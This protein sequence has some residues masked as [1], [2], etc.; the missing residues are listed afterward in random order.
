MFIKGN[1]VLC[2]INVYYI[3]SLCT[4]NAVINRFTEA[5]TLENMQYNEYFINKCLQYI[6]YNTVCKKSKAYLL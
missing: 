6:F 1:A 5:F 4:Y 2:E 3:T